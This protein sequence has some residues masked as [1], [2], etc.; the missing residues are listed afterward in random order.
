MHFIHAAIYTH[1]RHHPPSHQITH[2]NRQATGTVSISHAVQQYRSIRAL[3]ISTAALGI[4]RGR[5]DRRASL[6]RHANKRQRTKRDVVHNKFMVAF[7]GN[8]YH[9]G[10]GIKYAQ[11]RASSKGE[12]L[13]INIKLPDI[14]ACAGGTLVDAPNSVPMR[15]VLCVFVCVP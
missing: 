3:V 10:T 9:A 13:K 8:M 1:D 15:G 4:R 6:I 12:M 2:T 11:T 5:D 14:R 7:T